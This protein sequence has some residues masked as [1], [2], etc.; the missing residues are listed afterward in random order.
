M[1]HLDVMDGIFVP[2]ISFGVPV[3]QSIKKHT[4]LPLDVH[5]MIDRPH[6]YIEQFAKVADILGFHYEAGSNVANTLREIRA[7]GVKNCLTIKP[8]TP[9]EAIFEYLPLC[10]MVLIMSVDPGFGGQS[11]MPSSLKKAA[12]LRQQAGKLGLNFDIEIDGGIN[13][14]TA[15]LA[16][17]HGV[18]GLVAGSYL[19][20][21]PN[22]AERVQQLKAL[23]NA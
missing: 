14:E 9:A 1:L 7:L 10:D 18:N 4:R 3:I 13:R 16:V 6:R 15:A 8:Q 17:Q 5:L 20:G 23:E 19:V 12:A 21:A 11:F 2:N 22:A